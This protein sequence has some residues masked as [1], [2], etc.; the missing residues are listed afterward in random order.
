MREA[1]PARHR[2]MTCSTA[3]EAVLLRL[4]PYDMVRIITG[5]HSIQSLIRDT[6]LVM[7]RSMPAAATRCSFD[8]EWAAAHPRLIRFCR[9]Q[10]G[11]AA[12]ADD[13][14]QEVALR[15]WHGYG[16]FRRD[17][18]F[19]SWVF[20]IARREIARIMAGLGHRRRREQPIDDVVAGQLA[21]DDEIAGHGH[22]LWAP[23]VLD[24]AVRSGSI[25]ETEHAVVQARLAASEAD[26]AEIGSGLGLS[27]NVCAVAFCRAIPKLR[28]VLFTDFPEALGGLDAI[29]S[30]FARVD[31]GA[32]MLTA[33]EAEA[34]R[35]CVIERRNDY[36]RPGWRLDLRSACGKV[37]KQLDLDT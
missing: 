12:L 24:F 11:D 8:E 16:K 4:L 10:T 19:D 30:A 5:Q 20:T 2:M 29:A 36:R 21:G 31:A 7:A 25:S 33:G 23:A 1:S 9:S 18:S 17:A 32:A 35:R 15:A 37:I 22:E 26:W 14:L 28:V 3:N 34:F 13:V 27:G 6:S